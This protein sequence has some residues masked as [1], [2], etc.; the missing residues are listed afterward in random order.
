MNA[1]VAKNT[2]VMNIVLKFISF[3]IV[4]NQKREVFLKIKAKY[5]HLQ[6]IIG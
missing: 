1:W 5:I 4:F 3:R 6:A 2:L